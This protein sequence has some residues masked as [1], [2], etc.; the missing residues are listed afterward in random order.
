MSGEKTTEG[1]DLKLKDSADTRTKRYKVDRN[2]LRLEIRIFLSFRVGK[3][4]NI[5]PSH[6][7]R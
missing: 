3:V 6:I 4:W 7:P 1:E 2:K 5:L